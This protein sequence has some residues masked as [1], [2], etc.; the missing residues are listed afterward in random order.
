M[1]DARLMIS[2]ILYRRKRWIFGWME[3]RTKIDKDSFYEDPSAV[4][5][6][7][8][9]SP[10]PLSFLFLNAYGEWKIW[11]ISKCFNWFEIVTRWA[12]QCYKI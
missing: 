2:V 4:L 10:T 3:R 6:G 8:L 5:L 1:L 9:A 12:R 7:W 11:S